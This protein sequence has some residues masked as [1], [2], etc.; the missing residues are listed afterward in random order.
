M[1][2]GGWLKV[3]GVRESRELACSPVTAVN[4]SV[5]NTGHFLR[6]EISGA[7]KG[8]CVCELVW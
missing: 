6:G 3:C 5:G 1:W 2:G 4:N 7:L 8:N